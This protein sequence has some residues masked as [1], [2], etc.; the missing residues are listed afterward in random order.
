[1]LEIKPSVAASDPMNVTHD[2]L[3]G[4]A[5]DHESAAE[6]SLA[7]HLKLA[8]PADSVCHPAVENSAVH[9]DIARRHQPS[10]KNAALQ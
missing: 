4:F 8:V 7:A 10:R 3:I 5:F 6:V 1:M 9:H 2:C